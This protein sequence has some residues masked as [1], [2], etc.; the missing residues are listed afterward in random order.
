[1]FQLSEKQAQEIVDKMMMDIPYNI[2]I[3]NDQGI[4]I[5][6]GK[7]ERVGTVHKAA[8]EALATGQMVEVIEDTLYEKKGTNEPIVIG[9]T[10]V[11]V[12]G[13][14]GRP[15]EVRPFCN[16]VKTTVSLLIEQRTALENLMSEANRQKAWLE[17]LLAHQG[18][19]SQKLRKEAAPYKIDLLLKT[20]VLY[21]KHFSPEQDQAK[22][23]LMHPSFQLDEETWL[24]LVQNRPDTSKL[25]AQLLLQQPK[26][27]IAS[28]RLESSIAEGY[29]QAKAALNILL[30]LKPAAQAITFDE[31]E[32]LVKLSQAKLSDKAGTAM[33]LDDTADLLET[34]RSFINHNC[35]V[36]QTAEHLNI[37]RNTLQYRLKRIGGITG[38]DPRNLLQLFEL[39]YELLALYK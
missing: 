24:M 35:S 28:S 16:I 12:I 32:F 10:R 39:T 5:G 1:M 9:N 2:N 7:K 13:I 11:G 20:T 4:I 33:K 29:R 27:L 17:M 37:H 30:A 21:L 15:E 3:M 18:A 14:S 19:Y 31:A 25:A 8:V 26:L 22:L 23:M 34:L 36:S 6:S 38:K